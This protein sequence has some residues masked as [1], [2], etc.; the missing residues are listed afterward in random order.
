MSAFG[1]A[2]TSCNWPSQVMPKREIS[3]P[4]LKTRPSIFLSVMPPKATLSNFTAA[5]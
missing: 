4:S 2:R 1:V 3:R 5:A